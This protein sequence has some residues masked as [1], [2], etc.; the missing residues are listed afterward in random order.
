MTADPPRDLPAVCAW[1]RR[2]RDPLDYRWVPADP[3]PAAP[4]VGL[5]QGICPECFAAVTREVWR[6]MAGESGVCRPGG[7]PARLPA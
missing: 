6:T 1:C 5:A 2:L 7:G 4:A 3:D